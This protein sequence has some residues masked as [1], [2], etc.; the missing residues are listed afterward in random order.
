MSLKFWLREIS[1]INSAKNAVY[2]A[3]D[4]SFFKIE[5][6]KL[7]LNRLN[8]LLKNAEER[9][10]DNL[11]E[12]EEYVKEKKIVVLDIQNLIEVARK[13]KE[14]YKDLEDLEGMSDI[15]KMGEVFTKL[16]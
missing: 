1:L 12:D 11:Y 13:H 16:K 9:N 4:Y 2:K 3:S 15:I 10:L 7:L 14:E 8:N 5:E 6:L